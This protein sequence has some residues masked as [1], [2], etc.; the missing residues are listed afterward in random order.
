M[1][2][3]ASPK[4]PPRLSRRSAALRAAAD[5]PKLAEGLELIGEFE[6]SGFKEPQFIARRADGQVI[7]LTQLLYLVAEH[8]DGERDLGAIAE[9]VTERFGRGVSADNVS[10]L[11]EKR[12]RPLGVLAA[13]DGSSPKLKKAD[14]LLALK[15]RAALVPAGVVRAITTVF[16][17]LFAPPVIL[18]MLAGLAVLD[19]WLFLVHGVAQPARDLAYNPVLVLMVFGMIALSAAF[20]ECGHAT[21]CRYG[22]AKPGVMGAG[23]YVVWPAFYTDVTDAYRLGK[24][25]RLRTDLGGVYFNVIFSLATAGVYFL[26][27]FEPLLA[28]VV[29]QHVQIVYQFMPFLRLDGYYIISDLTGVPDM[30]ARIRPVLRSLI[31]GRDADPR[32]TELKPWVR[33]ATSV[34]VLTLIPA[35]TLIF[36]M[37][38]IAAPRLFATAWDSFFVQLDKVSGELRD[39]SLLAAAGAGIQMAALVLPS[40]GMGLTG[41]RVARRVGTFAWTSSEGKPALRGAYGLA[42][43]ALAGVLAFVWWPNGEYRPIQ[44]G[45]RGTLAGGVHSL[46][47]IP[48]GRPALTAARAAELGGAPLRS[49]RSAAQRANDEGP[50]SAQGARSDRPGES[51]PP[52]EPGVPEL[53]LPENDPEW[54]LESSPQE[55]SQQQPQPEQQPAPQSTTPSEQPTT[56][57]ETPPPQETTPTETTPTETQTEPAPQQPTTTPT[58]P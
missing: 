41:S 37:M 50:G 45:E 16:R 54:P 42:T 4:R 24:A 53:K 7:Q 12:L 18:A 6:D 22:G 57:E 35:L 44:P 15:F 55:P 28:I 5:R 39:G 21:A 52:E 20:H 1:T 17:P 25:G 32:V 2:T 23:I 33:V 34:Y 30:F 49:E 26:T 31:P 11:I 47:D 58:T 46:A 48:T 3:A 56:T 19:A 8:A 40:V 14:P 9:R 38:A 29:I 36:G 51:P 10:F 13:R 27:S 43:V